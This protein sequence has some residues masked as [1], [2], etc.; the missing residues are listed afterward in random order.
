LS[1]VAWMLNSWACNFCLNTFQKGI[2]IQEQN[3]KLPLPSY[4]AS[5]KTR[6]E[7]GSLFNLDKST[8]VELVGHDY[9]FEIYPEIKGKF[10]AY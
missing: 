9:L 3:D 10:Q 4:G 2:A 6:S 5:N 8:C 7:R 1:D